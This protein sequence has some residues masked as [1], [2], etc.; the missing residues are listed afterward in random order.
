MSRTNDMGKEVQ[1]ILR[2]INAN[3]LP[4]TVMG[5]LQEMLVFRNELE[6]ALIQ[7]GFEV[8]LF[9]L[10]DPVDD[11]T[12][13]YKNEVLFV[14]GLESLD[15]MESRSFSLRTILDVEQHQGL[16]FILSCEKDSYLKHFADYA[17]PF[18]KFCAPL[19]LPEF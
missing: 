9:D 4:V 7:N 1:G 16:R 5:T 12:I 8:K 11:L 10:H 14:W 3:M 17:A 6:G 19:K 13:D 18:Y 15:P 2:A